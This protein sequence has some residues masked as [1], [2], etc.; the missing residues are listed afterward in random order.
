MIAVFS[1]NERDF[2]SILEVTPN[3][4]FV[5]VRDINDLR[6][7]TFTGII[8]VRGWYKGMKNLIEAYDYLRVRQP[9]LFD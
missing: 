1:L 2:K 6:G 3:K 7:R 8:R 5:R 9:E 4:M